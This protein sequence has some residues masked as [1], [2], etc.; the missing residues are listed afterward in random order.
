MCEMVDIDCEDQHCPP[1]PFCI[2][3]ILAQMSGGVV[4]GKEGVGLCPQGTPYLSEETNETL[5][6]NPR[7][8]MLQ[9]PDDHFCHENELCCPIL[10]PEET[11][12]VGVGGQLLMEDRADPTPLRELHSGADN[13]LEGIHTKVG[14]CPSSLQ[15]LPPFGRGC[16]S[17]CET[18]AHCE[19]SRKCCLT[20]CGGTQCIQ[21]LSSAAPSTHC[22][23]VREKMA[24]AE[25]SGGRTMSYT[26]TCDEEGAWAPTQCFQ[27]IGMCW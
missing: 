17:E 23:R 16:E 20:A 1:L 18:D 24:E 21:P 5:G 22:Q 7:A 13:L 9:C 26:P 6:C 3:K 27:E 2:P 19:G 11:E 12:G 8:R 14:Q 15:T 25:N 4:E 10:L